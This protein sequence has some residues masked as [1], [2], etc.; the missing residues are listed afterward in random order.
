ML[1]ENRIL[2][3]I[4]FVMGLA[5]TG[6]SVADVIYVDDSSTALEPTGLS[7][8]SAFTDLQDGLGAAETGDEVW[9]AAGVYLPTDTSTATISFNL[10]AGVD[11]YGG[12][13]GNED[14][15]TFDMADRDLETNAT[16]LSGELAGGAT[17]NR[18]IYALNLTN[19]PVLDGFTITGARWGVWCS[20]TDLT[21]RNCVVSDNDDE[22]IYSTSG[23]D[24]VISKCVVENNGGR[25][26]WFNGVSHP[27]ITHTRIRDNGEEG[28]YCYGE[29]TTVTNNWI[30]NNGMD[31]IYFYSPNQNDIVRNNTVV[32]NS[33]GGI[34]NRLVA[35]YTPSISNCI[36]WGNEESD[37]YNCEATYSCIEDGD[38]GEGN[39]AVVP[40]FVNAAAYDF[41]LA[42]TSPCVN[43]GDQDVSGIEIDE[44]DIDGDGRLFGWADMGA[45]ELRCEQVYKDFDLNGDGIADY[46]DFAQFSLAW[47]ADKET[48]DWYLYYDLCDVDCDG[49]IQAQD[50]L[51]MAD[52]WLYVGCDFDFD[53]DGV[54]AYPD[55]A[56]FAKAWLS[57][58]GEGNWNAGCDCNGS[59]VVDAEDLGAFVEEWLY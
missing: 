50:L 47:L 37:L 13:A 32:Y 4:A 59:G 56:V 11:M 6:L 35:F 5:M 21:I 22:G 8:E 40:K 14:P 41:H 20:N 34:Y 15:A 51:G 2:L 44:V 1:S 19:A 26:I 58:D 10:I 42:G 57:A 28:L 9:V 12:L 53:D 48:D 7:W 49:V 55:F 43:T 33:G 27:T 17:S 30:H 24:P 23:S 38:A 25:G 52:E 39:I 31:G 36:L 3:L 54:V 16:I 45:D 29:G 18:I 46:A